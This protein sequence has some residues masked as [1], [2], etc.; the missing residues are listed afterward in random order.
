MAVVLRN[1]KTYSIQPRTDWNL[2]Q[3]LTWLLQDLRNLGQNKQSFIPAGK[4]VCHYFCGVVA[5]KLK[6]IAV[7]VSISILHNQG[8]LP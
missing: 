1:Y 5:L 7:K 3:Q 2:T 6:I 8:Q 4:Y